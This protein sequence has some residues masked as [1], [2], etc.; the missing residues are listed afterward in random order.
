MS[1]EKIITRPEL[2]HAI[3]KSGYEKPTPIQEQIIP[4]IK[5][6]KDVIGQAQTGTG[7]TAAFALP[8]LSQ[9]ELENRDTQILVIAPIRELAIQVAKQ[10][11]N[12]GKFMMDLRV[13][14]LYGGAEYRTQLKQLKHG[15]QVVVGTPGRIKDHLKRKTLKLGNLKAVVLDEADEMLRMGFQEEVQEILS[16]TPDNCQKALL[17]ATMPPQIRK[18]A[19]KFLKDPEHVTISN[20]H[21]SSIEQ[22]YWPVTGINKLDALTRMAEL[23]DIESGLIFVKTRAATVELAAKLQHRKIKSVFINGDLAQNQRERAIAEFKKGNVKFLI[24]TDVA[25]RGLDIQSVTHVINYDPPYDVESYTH[26]IGRTGRAGR[27]GKAILFLA[28]RESRLLRKIEQGTKSKI[29]RMTLPSAKDISARRIAKFH[30]TLESEIKKDE[31]LQHL[32]I[33]TQFK[34]ENPEYSNQQII[35]ALCKLANTDSPL[36]L[37]DK[38]I[39]FDEFKESWDDKKG[40]GR[41]RRGGRGG[42]NH[43]GGGGGGGGKRYSNGGGG[44]GGRR[45]GGGG[46]RRR[47]SR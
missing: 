14:L 38:V 12:Y 32:D 44:G 30:D 21:K 45:N 31:K 26:R 22:V 13:C 4:L 28:P 35:A 29:A 9:I 41:R 34:E 33:I 1:F 27:K 42:S 39:K 40:G 17:S 37:K 5:A 8:M 20:E 10:F 2:I 43:R 23:E 16:Y 25:S 47:N 15:S 18:L 7:K 46:G 11:E 24:A 19:S 6:G 3:K 36:F